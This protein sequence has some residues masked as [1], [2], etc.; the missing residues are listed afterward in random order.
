MADIENKIALIIFVITDIWFNQSRQPLL[1]PSQCE[2]AVKRVLGLA[3]CLCFSIANRVVDLL[4]E[5]DK[6]EKQ[7][8]ASIIS[9]VSKQ[10]NMGPKDSFLKS[11]Q[12]ARG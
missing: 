9:Q 5:N 6:N 12:Q 8:M 10:L 2:V 1:Q 3:A 11:H 7:G 4:R